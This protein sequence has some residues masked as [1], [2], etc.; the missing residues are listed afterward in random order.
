MIHRS[1]GCNHLGCESR[2]ATKDDIHPSLYTI[3][4]VNNTI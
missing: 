1:L 3:I 4:I 2:Y